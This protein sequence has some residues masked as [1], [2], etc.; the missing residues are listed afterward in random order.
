MRGECDVRLH[1]AGDARNVVP[2]A[3]RGLATSCMRL[4]I[5]RPLPCEPNR[6]GKQK[7]GVE[8]DGRDRL[9]IANGKIHEHDI[10]QSESNQHSAAA[11]GDP[12]TL[13]HTLTEQDQPKHRVEDRPDTHRTIAAGFFR[14]L[15]GSDKKIIGR[16][17]F[18]HNVFCKTS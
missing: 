15:L 7:N 5:T 6:H 16:S 9:T 12:A 17:E 11:N 4:Q 14:G 1:E 18:M 8:T 13:E 3:S 10:Q 2:F